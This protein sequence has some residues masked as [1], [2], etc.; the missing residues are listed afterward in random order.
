MSEAKWTLWP[1]NWT[2]GGT[3][4]SQCAWWFFFFSSLSLFFFFFFFFFLPA[5]KHMEVPW[6]RD[7]IW[8]KASTYATAI[9]VQDPLTHSAWLGMEP[10]SW[11]HRDAADAVAPHWEL[12][13][14][15]FWFV[16]AF[17]FSGFFFVCLFCFFCFCYTHCF[18]SFHCGS[19]RY[20][21]D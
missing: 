3:L 4:W 11:H 8:T 5:L 21:P 2:Q 9:A 19:V 7:Q 1:S 15:I 10:V 6:A 14:P 12:L 13:D 20:K 17:V 16:F 18:R